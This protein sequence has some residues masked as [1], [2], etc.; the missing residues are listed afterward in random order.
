MN[1]VSIRANEAFTRSSGCK[2]GF[3][4]NAG[5]VILKSNAFLGVHQI[6]TRKN[7][8]VGKPIGWCKPL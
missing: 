4:T 5:K 7:C 2:T 1:T 6:D 8:Q 3:I